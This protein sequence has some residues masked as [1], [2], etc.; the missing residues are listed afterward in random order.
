MIKKL[1]FILCLLVLGWMFW[2]ANPSQLWEN[3]LRWNW[4]LVACVAVWAVGYLLN[5]ASFRYVIQCYESESRIGWTRVL[6]L[7]IGGYALNYV[8]PFGL[9]GGEPWR[10]VQL[11]KQMDNQS[12]NSSVTYYAMMHVLSHIL[13]WL[14]GMVLGLLLNVDANVDAEPLVVISIIL[15]IA[16]LVCVLYR[17]AVAKGW[18]ASIRQLLQEH[19]AYFFKAL[20]LELASRM[21]NVLEYWILMHFVFPDSVLGSYISAYLVVAFSSLFANLLFF[22]PMQM[23]TREGGIFLALQALEPSVPELFPI[24]VSISF[25]TRIREFIWIIIGLSIVKLSK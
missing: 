25:A 22:S 20:L 4:A 5:T 3:L 9:L 13:F 11:R 8:T 16:V 18:I 15:C 14:L 12:A 23:G 10:I 1:L 17:F 2:Q 21:V 19:P 24:A 7:T 6:C